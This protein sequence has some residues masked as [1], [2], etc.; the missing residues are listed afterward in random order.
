M[1]LRGGPR[2]GMLDRDATRRNCS[3][4]TENGMANTLEKGMV[5][6][7]ETEAQ[8]AQSEF[9]LARN[10]ELEMRARELKDYIER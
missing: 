3:E 9:A 2:W 6:A 4:E 1:I 5:E 7:D 10:E 8:N